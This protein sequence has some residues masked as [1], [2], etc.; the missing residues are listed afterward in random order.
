MGLN[1]LK[2]PIRQNSSSYYKIFL[3]NLQY[4]FSSNILESYFPKQNLENNSSNSSSL[5]VA[6]IISPKSS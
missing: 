5:Y 1:K 4:L 3:I 6:P 2:I